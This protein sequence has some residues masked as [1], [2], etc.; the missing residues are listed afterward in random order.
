MFLIS[1]NIFSFIYTK[2]KIFDKFIL[3]TVNM[4]DEKDTIKFV[5][6]V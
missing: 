2:E 1:P 6:G 4:A 5:E 3:V